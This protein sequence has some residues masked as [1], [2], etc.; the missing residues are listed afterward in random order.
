MFRFSPSCRSSEATAAL[1]QHTEIA[2]NGLNTKPPW[3][4][5]T[6]FE[7][8]EYS[9]VADATKKVEKTFED[10]TG[11]SPLWF[12]LEGDEEGG[13]DFFGKDPRQGNVMF[14]DW[15]LD[16]SLLDVFEDQSDTSRS[17]SEKQVCI[18]MTCRA[19]KT[20]RWSFKACVG[21]SLAETNCLRFVYRM[22]ATLVLLCDTIVLEY[23]L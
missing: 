22:S 7:A 18:C 21:G 17:R 9:E 3:M 14:G 8:F 2:R 23:Y 15:P 12:G 10:L 1:H 16:E 4:D 20:S 6:R 19:A 11:V 13:G 5:A